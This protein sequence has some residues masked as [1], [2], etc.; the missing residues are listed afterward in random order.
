[1]T[2]RQALKESI[3][4]LESG[5][6]EEARLESELLLRHVLG[7]SKA[8]LCIR[9][10]DTLSPEQSQRLNQLIQ[11]RL[12]HEPTAYITGHKEFFGIDFYV[13][14]STLIPRPETE[15]MV[16]KSLELALDNPSLTIID[17]GTGCGAIAIA[18]ATHLPQAK[19]Y[20]ID[21]SA[22]ALKV[23]A[24][25][26]KFH[27]VASR[28]HLMQSDLLQSITEPA[29][30]IVANLPY[31]SDPE[32]TILSDEILLYEPSLALAGGPDG[33]GQIKRLLAQTKG[34]LRS[35]GAILLEIG[36]NQRT[37]VVSLINKNFPGSTAR[38]I[39]DLSGYDRIIE[40]S[41]EKM[42]TRAGNRI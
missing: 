40:I 35:G 32:M 28:V 29:D 25:N 1:M 3:E 8:E 27:G 39:Q 34:K 11:R 17:V 33:L 36:Q 26:S 7:W 10:E 2:I 6:I 30:L 37:S 23:A 5:V 9:L 13:N 41:Y 38:V 42:A 12:N 20:A 24:L 14:Q 4:T 21:I 15:I 19:V 18:L 22:S 16:E 31:I